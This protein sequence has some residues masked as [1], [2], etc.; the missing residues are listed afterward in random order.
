[1]SFADPTV[2][3]NAI[4]AGATFSQNRLVQGGVVKWP[5]LSAG[6]WSLSTS[7]VG[8]CQ[9]SRAAYNILKAPSTTIVA[10][11]DYQY[12]LETANGTFQLVQETVTNPDNSVTNWCTLNDP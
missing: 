3:V 6:V 1:M 10:S 5:L 4:K 2:V 9:I 12:C 8:A 11:G 7:P